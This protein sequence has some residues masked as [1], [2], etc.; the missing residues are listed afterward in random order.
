MTIPAFVA[1]DEEPFDAESEL[2]PSDETAS[3]VVEA[4]Q[5]NS[6]GEAEWACSH[7]AASQARIAELTAQATEWH[8]RI[9]DWLA[10]ESRGYEHTAEFFEGRLED[11]GHRRRRDDPRCKT[12]TLPSGLIKTQDHKERVVVEDE[13]RL[14]KWLRE[15]APEALKVTET[16]KL[17]ELRALASIDAGEAHLQGEMIPGVTIEPE[18]VTVKVST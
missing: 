14:V 11:Y 15:S 12:I 4:W 6:T 10:T 16:V 9:I 5:V 7:L 8:Q 3:P 17:R 18:H 2:D 1:V 13:E